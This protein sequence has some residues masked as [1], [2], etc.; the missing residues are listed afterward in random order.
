[1]TAWKLGKK[2]ASWLRE[3]LGTNLI[4]DQSHLRTGNMADDLESIDPGVENSYNKNQSVVR[5]EG[6]GK[7]S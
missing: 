3:E 4:S 2:N 1:M 6:K 7:N 5:Q